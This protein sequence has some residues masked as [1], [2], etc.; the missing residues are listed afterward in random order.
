MTSEQALSLIV[1]ICIVP[2]I[3]LLVNTVE[4]WCKKLASRSKTAKAEQAARIFKTILVILNSHAVGTKLEKRSSALSSTQ[5]GVQAYS[6]L[7]LILSAL[8]AQ[9]NIK[10]HGIGDT[11][12]K[13]YL[14]MSLTAGNVSLA[15]EHNIDVGHFYTAM[16]SPE[17]QAVYDELKLEI[18]TLS[19]GK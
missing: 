3:V 4:S 11:K 19:W 5:R 18:D 17:M 8:H 12:D 10:V 16:F 13:A 6:A 1:V 7:S 14:I 2:L 9:T 15:S